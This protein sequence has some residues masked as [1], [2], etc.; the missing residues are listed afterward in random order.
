MR[1]A[2]LALA[3]V[4]AAAPAQ[5]SIGA[6]EATARGMV[7]GRVCQDLD[8]DGRCGEGDPG[9]GGVRLLLD[10]GQVALADAS[11]RFHF[12]EVP[13]RLLEPGRS[14][15]GGHLLALETS[16]G[17]PA[18]KRF[19][20]LPPGGAAEV[21][22]AVPATAAVRPGPTL[23][24]TAR[25]PAEGPRREG[26]GLR[27]GL[28]G[29]APTGSRVEVD[30]KAAAVQADGSW[31]APVVLRPGE[32]PF[33]LSVR[34]P[35]GR[36]SLY[37]QAVHLARRSEGGDLVVPLPPEWLATLALPPDDVLRGDRARLRG[38]AADGVSL[39][40]GGAAVPAGRAGP[41]E[42]RPDLSPGQ[43]PLPVE[44]R[45]GAISAAAS[46]VVRFE[47]GGVTVVALADLEVS[48]GGGEARLAGRGALAAR[49]ALGPVEGEAGFDLDDRDRSL[50][51]LW[52]PRDPLALERALSP[53]RTLPT[54]GDDAAADDPNAA[55]G[56]LYARL[57]ATGASI[58]LGASRAGSTG[59]ELGRFDRAFFGA[60]ASAE[61]TLGSVHL[62][63][64]LF[65]ASARPAEGQAGV[66]VPAHDVLQA[67]G[68][69]LFWLRH[70]E[71]VAG[72][73][74]LRVEWRDQLTGR[75]V[76]QRTL[77]R[78]VD[79]QIDF[80][81]GRVL[82]AVPL[83]SVSGQPA[84]ATGD[85]LSAPVAT[86]VADY[87]HASAQTADD[88]VGGRLGVSFG[89]LRLDGS[90]ASEERGGSRYRLAAGGADLDLGPLL[91]ARAEVA[92]SRG[93]AAGTGWS[94]SS[95]GGLSFAAPPAPL[96]AEATAWHLQAGGEGLGVRWRGWWRDRPQGYS[97]WEFQQALAALERG[98]SASWKGGPASAEALWA[99]RRGSDPR[100]PT[101]LSPLDATDLRLRAGW[102]F[103][104][105]RLLGEALA[106]RATASGLEGSGTGA[107]LRADWAMR[108]DLSLNAAW[109]QSLDRQG[110]G[111]AARD[112]TYFGVGGSLRLPDGSASAEAGWGPDLGPRLLLSGEQRA[113]DGTT[114]GSFAFDPD[115]PAFARETA[116]S[117]GVRRAEDGAEV[118]S[119]DQFARDVFGLR[120]SRVS[121][122]TLQPM[123]G[124]RLTA[125][126]ESGS[127]LQLD[128]TTA[129]RW[130]AGGTAAWLSGRI[131]LSGRGEAREDGDR[132]QWL[133]GAAAEWRASER[134]RLAGRANWSR[135]SAAG[136]PGLAFEGSLGAAWRGDGLQL[137]GK[138]AALADQRPGAALRE[139]ALASL[140][141]TVAAASRL[142]LGL[143][144][145][146]GANRLAGARVDLVAGSVRALVRVVGPF[147]GA[148]EYA[149]R[150]VLRGPSPEWLDAGRVE[151]G[152]SFPQGRLALG[153][154]VFG[155]AGS[156]VDP[157]AD[158]G[159]VYFRADVG[160]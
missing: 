131:R 57:R 102:S 154:N 103:G 17:E 45:R 138:V 145:S 22:L 66:P 64:A 6:A 16:P 119:E 36:L 83:A 77:T 120:A 20:E 100:D 29:L 96:E 106:T 88:L 32:N 139:Q 59:R 132:R 67:T 144:A 133:A 89:P 156:G 150:Q 159:R 104:E 63:G 91:K 71:V 33:S 40:V 99:E 62:D 74:G 93:A 69:S 136:L 111:P 19:F 30:G 72:S 41:F 118:W 1:A 79:Y 9:L 24:R 53:E 25:G 126:A 61:G 80:Q 44:A 13:A 114:Y 129:G 60:R 73:E 153:Y 27:W 39:T 123:P 58:D 141:A 143:A 128:G 130:A 108:E 54:A 47:R 122:V 134:L 105:V 15:Y 28:S 7:L 158:G 12:L 149:R 81:S 3:L 90:A 42:V 160:I 56:R 115:A 76:A 68:G 35:D 49:G 101:G 65:G 142:D 75:V 34:E 116:A 112:D 18:V 43:A 78:T 92:Q 51:D 125:R 31:L 38:V 117:L 55:R 135:S 21:D 110:E 48:A 5:V 94:T 109:H 85:P 155:F 52:T 146:Y 87:L 86:L 14:A 84:L 137:T 95:D 8:G 23:A 4:P 152:W 70:A 147:D 82:L 46:P 127:R 151:A 124:L 37:R 157:D 97:D 2:T 50:Q 11:G 26:E 107:G 10:G 140:A 121:G 113:S 98:L 148:A